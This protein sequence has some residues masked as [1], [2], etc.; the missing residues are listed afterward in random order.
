M[1]RSQKADVDNP[2]FPDMLRIF[3]KSTL[4]NI[5]PG[6]AAGVSTPISC[7]E[8]T[9]GGGA[10]A[11]VRGEKCFNLKSCGKTI[12]NIEKAFPRPPSGPK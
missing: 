4:C 9:T 6:T 3:M 12:F 11:R 1:Q 2:M 5:S 8:V 10:R 7:G